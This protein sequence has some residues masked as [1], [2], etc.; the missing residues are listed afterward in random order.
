MSTM[1]S[2]SITYSAPRITRWSEVEVCSFE[3]ELMAP[4]PPASHHRLGA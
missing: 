4:P 3:L 2:M 1:S